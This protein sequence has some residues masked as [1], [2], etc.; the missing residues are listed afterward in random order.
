MKNE[1]DF[2]HAPQ[3]LPAEPAVVHLPLYRAGSL[4]GY[5]GREYTVDH[6][7]ITRSQLLVHL[8]ELDSSVDAEKLQVAP[9]RLVLQRS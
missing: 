8:Q 6:V 2:L 4:V 9:T 7:V 1:A 3:D 5:Q